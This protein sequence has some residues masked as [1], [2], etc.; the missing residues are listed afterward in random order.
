MR[1]RDKILLVVLD[2]TSG[3]TLYAPSYSQQ[4]ID[5]VLLILRVKN[6]EEMECHG[7]QQEKTVGAIKR[8]REKEI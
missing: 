1:T 5:G 4:Q 3:Y 6:G 8:C 7:V 2:C